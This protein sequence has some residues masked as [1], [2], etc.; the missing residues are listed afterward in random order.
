MGFVQLKYRLRHATKPIFYFF[1]I[2]F[3]VS[4]A[5]SFSSYQSRHSGMGGG[6]PKRR[7]SR[8]VAVV[9]GQEIPR[10]S[11]DNYLAQISHQGAGLPV[12]MHRMAIT[13]W[14][15]STINSILMEQAERQEKIRVSHKELEDKRMQAVDEILAPQIQERVRLAKTLEKEQLT[16]DE[17]KQKLAR[18]RF[19]DIEVFRSELA[20]EKLQK[21]IE[22]QVK[23]PTDEGLRNS[24]MEAK[25]RHILISP[26]DMKRKAEAK[27]DE[28]KARLQAPLDEA[29][30]AG[31]T[32]DPAVKQRLDALE[33]E[34]QALNRRNFDDEA[35]KKAEELR[36]ALLKGADFAK[37]AQ[38]NSDDPGSGAKGGDLGSL[39]RG[40]TVPEFDQVA[41][42]LPLGQISQ[43][44]KTRF[45]YH[46]LRADQ[47][48]LKLP[49][50]FDKNK[51]MLRT[52]YVQEQKNRAWGEYRNKLKDNAKIE[53]RD[54]ELQAYRMLDESGDEQKAIQLL[55][56]AVQQDSQ[57]AGAMY[58]LAQLWRGKGNEAE[59][60]K[61]LQKAEK[62][63]GADRSAE[64]MYTLGQLLQ[65]KNDAAQAIPYYQKASDLTAP[66][67]Q[68]NMFMHQRLEAAFNTLK[69]PDLAKQETDWLDRMKKA[70]AEQGGPGGMMQ[71]PGGTF[72]VP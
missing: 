39:R 12:D 63:P 42:A 57:N 48:E 67:E 53:V 15:D 45:G 36:Q 59:A 24:F 23:P 21:K 7:V 9:K 60:L 52:Q 72:N 34:Q 32:P 58:E 35:K 2:V 29:K 65:A 26:K 11:L 13:Q 44:V 40:Q 30:K 6:G 33:V 56:L 46:L 25:A 55:D 3:L 68:Q 64:L 31:K 4:G 66:V 37:T 1:V 51:D 70:Q 10:E 62:V 43:V 27:L 18:E 20:E 16:L 69:R 49:K 54:P 14:L 17:Y 50:D 71:M 19:K 47:R 5:F 41:F 8:V 28:E 61:L 22:D 38:E